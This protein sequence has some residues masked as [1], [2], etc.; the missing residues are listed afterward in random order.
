VEYTFSR[1]VYLRIVLKAMEWIQVE[2]EASPRNP[3]R[4][5]KTSTQTSC[6]ASSAVSLRKII[7]RQMA[8]TT[9]PYSSA[10]A[11]AEIPF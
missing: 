8:D 5:L 9:G 3:G 11:W 1:Y 2:S 4:L 7:R 10:T 6:A